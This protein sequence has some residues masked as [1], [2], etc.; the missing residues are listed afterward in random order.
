MVQ[1]FYVTKIWDNNQALVVRQKLIYT[2]IDVRKL[3]VLS[4]SLTVTKVG[5]NSARL[6]CYFDPV[7]PFLEVVCQRR[8]LD[9]RFETGPRIMPFT[10][11]A[12]LRFSFH[13]GKYREVLLHF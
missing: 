11:A 1:S 5:L 2:N 8:L 6:P 7:F 9:D 10:R 4:C 3:E 13:T 12:V